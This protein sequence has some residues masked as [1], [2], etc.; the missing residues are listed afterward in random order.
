VDKVTA[1]CFLKTSKLA[2]PE[3]LTV[4]VGDVSVPLDAANGFTLEGTEKT[5][6]LLALHGAACDHAAA[7]DPVTVTAT[8]ECPHR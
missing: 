4:K 6:Q 3:Q 5:G 1:S 8:E 2:S 7:G